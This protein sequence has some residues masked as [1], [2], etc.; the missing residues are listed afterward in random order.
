[1]SR[2]IDIILDHNEANVFREVMRREKCSQGELL[3]RIVKS[4]AKHPA[5]LLSNVPLPDDNAVLYKGESLRQYL[6]R[7]ALATINTV[8]EREGNMTKTA[9]R[10]RH[11]RSGLYERIARLKL[12]QKSLP[13]ASTRHGNSATSVTKSARLSSSNHHSYACR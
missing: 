4:W 2:D 1:M 10:L 3:T 11:D 8:Q 6:A 13:V 9:K 12:L 5:R 7:T